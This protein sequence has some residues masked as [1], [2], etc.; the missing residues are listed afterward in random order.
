VVLFEGHPT[1]L[2]AGLTGADLLIVDAGMIP[3]LQKDWLEVALQVMWTSEIRVYQPNG[4]VQQ[5]VT[6]K[7]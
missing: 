1:A 2:A 5:I 4:R 7:S 6:N 3:F